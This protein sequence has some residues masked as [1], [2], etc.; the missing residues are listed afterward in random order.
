M[1]LVNPQG[2]WLRGEKLS[3]G[4]RSEYQ[5]K[6]GLWELPLV[7]LRTLCVKERTWHPGG[8]PRLKRGFAEVGQENLPSQS[9]IFCPAAPC[10]KKKNAVGEGAEAGGR[11]RASFFWGAGCGVWVQWTLCTAPTPS[12]ATWGS[13]L[14]MSVAQLL[15]LSKSFNRTSG[16]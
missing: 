12:S 3:C 1:G 13:S 8:M 15:L 9:G 5:N 7:L 10:L 4:E 14:H 6:S 11:G 2:R 16:C